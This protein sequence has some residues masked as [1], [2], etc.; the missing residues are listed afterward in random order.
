MKKCIKYYIITAL[1]FFFSA[2]QEEFLEYVPENQATVNAWYR[3]ADEI[4]QSTAALY[5]RPW[6]RFNDEFGWVVNDVMSGDM[7]HNWDQEGQFFYLSFNE[8]NTYIGD[9]WQGLYDVISY[10]NLIID[11][12]PAIA[13]GDRKSVV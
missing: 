9:G 4:R 2:C 11:D 7:H 3:N 12:M 13:G 6:F 10:S 8:N 5:G 1:L